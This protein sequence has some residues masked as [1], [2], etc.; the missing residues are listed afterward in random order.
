MTGQLKPH[1]MEAGGQEAWP[2]SLGPSL[3]P[4]DLPALKYVDM[5]YLNSLSR[6]FST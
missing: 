3:G 2:V 4:G 1:P 5:F 6:C